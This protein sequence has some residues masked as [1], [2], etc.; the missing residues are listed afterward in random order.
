MVFSEMKHSFINPYLNLQFDVIH[1]KKNR[2]SKLIVNF[3]AVNVTF[4]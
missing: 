1:K 4:T 2:I 3:T